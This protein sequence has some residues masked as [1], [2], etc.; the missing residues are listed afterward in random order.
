M[1]TPCRRPVQSSKP[2]TYCSLGNRASFASVIS[3]SRTWDA[4]VPNLERLLSRRERSLRSLLL[5]AEVVDLGVDLQPG[6]LLARRQVRHH[7]HE[8]AH[9]VLTNPSHQ[10]SAL[11]G[12]ADHH[13][14]A[15][16]R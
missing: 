7:G 10:R 2:L 11:F 14:P 6:L 16:V 15:V 4:E 8:V 5:L 9:H 12:D 13:F 1:Q 3:S